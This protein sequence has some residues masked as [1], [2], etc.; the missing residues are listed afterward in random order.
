MNFGTSLLIIF[1][2]TCTGLLAYWFYHKYKIEREQI[3][4]MQWARS[5]MREKYDSDSDSNS[6]NTP[7]YRTD[8]AWSTISTDSSGTNLMEGGNYEHSISYGAVD[9]SSSNNN[10]G[11]ESEDNYSF[12]ATHIK[13]NVHN[14]NNNPSNQ[15]YPHNDYNDYNVPYMKIDNTSDN[16]LPVSTATVITNNV[17]KYR[18]EHEGTNIKTR[19]LSL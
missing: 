9:Y 14:N 17:K 10:S 15:K 19:G 12:D 1:I 6:N 11:A 3:R 16:Q 2:L 5:V 8:S 18:Q 13:N 7:R 4:F